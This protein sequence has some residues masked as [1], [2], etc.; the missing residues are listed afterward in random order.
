LFFSEDCQITKHEEL[1]RKSLFVTI[2]ALMH[3]GK[4]SGGLLQAGR[5]EAGNQR[6]PLWRKLLAITVTT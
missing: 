6:K 3:L 2:F 1:T 5:L 4:L